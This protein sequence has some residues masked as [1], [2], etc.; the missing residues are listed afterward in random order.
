MAAIET[1]ARAPRVLKHLYLGPLTAAHDLQ[2]LQDRNIRCIINCTPLDPFHADLPAHI[3]THRVPVEDEDTS[4]ANLL[5]FQCIPEATTLMHGHLLMQHGV[6][7]HCYAGRSRSA[8]VVTA[9]LMM[10][11][12]CCM[13][14]ARTRVRKSRPEA[15]RQ[16]IFRS[17]LG[18]WENELRELYILKQG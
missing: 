18:A 16:L 5:M 7:V 8:T 9:Y 10:K 17:A 3:E 1:R 11:H 15:L 6:L 12:H 4:E 14:L 13:H 2:L